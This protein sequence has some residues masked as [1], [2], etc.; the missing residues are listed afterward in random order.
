MVVK[1]QFKQKVNHVS[2]NPNPNRCSSCIGIYSIIALPTSFT[3]YCTGDIE[4]LPENPR[5]LSAISCMPD[6]HQNRT[7]SYLTDCVL[8]TLL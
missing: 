6:V 3:D 5:E 4:P 2:I 1:N 7:V 8:T